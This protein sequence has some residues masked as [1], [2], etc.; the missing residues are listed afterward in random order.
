MLVHV[1][2][3]LEVSVTASTVGHLWM[4][5]YLLYVLSRLEVKLTLGGNRWGSG[6]SLVVACPA[7]HY[8][9]LYYNKAGPIV[10]A[11]S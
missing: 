3:R 1:I 7:S 6:H 5:L 2:V 11:L 10:T 9:L 4:L 8:N